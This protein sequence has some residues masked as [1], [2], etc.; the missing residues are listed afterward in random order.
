MGV[1]FHFSHTRHFAGVALLHVDCQQ[2]KAE[3]IWI[4]GDIGAN[5]TSAHAKIRHRRGNEALSQLMAQESRLTAAGCASHF[6][7]I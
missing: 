7:G 1:A 2:V 6:N 5:H 3:K 4:A